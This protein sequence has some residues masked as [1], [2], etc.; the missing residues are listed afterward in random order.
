MDAIKNVGHGAVEE[1]LRARKKV[2]K[3][4]SIEDLAVNLGARAFRALFK[5]PSIKRV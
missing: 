2:G 5:P 1:I 4:N 3:F